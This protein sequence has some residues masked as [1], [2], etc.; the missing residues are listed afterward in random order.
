M[1]DNHCKLYIRQRINMQT[2]QTT[3]KTNHTFILIA[4]VSVFYPRAS[5]PEHLSYVLIFSVL[6]HTIPIW[7]Q[8][9][10]YFSNYESTPGDLS[11]ERCQEVGELRYEQELCILAMNDFP[12]PLN[13]SLCVPLWARTFSFKF[14]I[15]SFLFISIHFKNYICSSSS[16]YDQKDVHIHR[17]PWWVE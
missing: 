4:R 1:G 8:I 13:G 15:L 6:F 2:T 12:V 7:E 9:F 16:N 10:F 14:K 11:L 5:Y 17:L 3:Q